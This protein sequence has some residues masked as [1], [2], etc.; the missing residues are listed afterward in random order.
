M[1]L[2]INIHDVTAVLL[3]DG[4]HPVINESFDLDAYEYMDGSITNRHGDAKRIYAGEYQG[5]AT[6][7]TFITDFDGEGSLGRLSGPVTSILAI[8]EKESKRQ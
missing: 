4:W 2:E 1:S 8:Q 6:G 3:N 7:F 5:S